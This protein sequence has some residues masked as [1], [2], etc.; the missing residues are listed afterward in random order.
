[1]ISYGIGKQT[2]AFAYTM[3]RVGTMAGALLCGLICTKF[4]LK[5]VLG[6]LYLLRVILIAVFTFLLPKDIVTV[7]GFAVTL[8]LCGDATVTP[9]SEIISRRFG[10]RNMAFLFGI[11]FVCHQTGAFVSTWLGGILLG[12][13]GGYHVIWLIDA[14]LCAL[15]ALV[16]Y[17][18]KNREAF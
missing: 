9:T 8:G 4:S 7:V 6:S 16:S 2:A 17:C 11:V 5:N 12:A 1:M 10:N 13:T 15:A 14:G 3:F 18:I